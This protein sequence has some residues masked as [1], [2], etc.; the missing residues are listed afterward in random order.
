LSTASTSGITSKLQDTQTWTN[1]VDRS[2]ETKD[3]KNAGTIKMN[4]DWLDPDGTKLVP[5]SARDDVP[6]APKLR[7]IDVIH[8]DRATTV[9]FGRRQDCCLESAWLRRCRK[10]RPSRS[11][12]RTGDGSRASGCDQQ[13]RRRRAR[14]AVWGKPS[15]WADYSGERSMAKSWA[16]RS[17][18][19]RRIRVRRWHE[20]AYGLFAANP[21][22]LAAFT[23]DKSQD[24][25]VTLS[26]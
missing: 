14:E 1:G 17:W 19:I 12:A 2:G 3:G 21:F 25:S 5:G 11:A 10:T 7:M 15:N 20:R 26:R 23:G 4:F 6:R 9:K 13:C 8:A 22:G 16:S 24:G 18:I